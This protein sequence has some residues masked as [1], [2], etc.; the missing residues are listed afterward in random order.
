MRNII[1][2]IVPMCY[3]PGPMVILYYDW[4]FGVNRLLQLSRLTL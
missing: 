3:F 4:R 1:L 2:Y